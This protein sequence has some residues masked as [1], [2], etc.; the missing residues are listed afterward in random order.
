MKESP[1][2]GRSRSPEPGEQWT[3]L[4]LELILV[5]ALALRLPGLADW[6]FNPDE[7]MIFSVASWQHLADCITDLPTEPHP[8]LY[9]L[10]VR[11]TLAMGDSL[12]WLRLPSLI[13]SLFAIHALFLLARSL[14]DVRTALLSAI[15]LVFAS[16]P[17]TSAQLLRSYSLWL[18]FQIYALAFFVQWIQTS[19]RRTL[20]LAS[21][22]WCLS[23]AT[24]YFALTFLPMAALLL[25]RGHRERPMTRRQLGAL[26]WATLPFLLL[27]ALLFQFHF[28]PALLENAGQQAA[29]QRALAEGLGGGLANL[30]LAFVSL[31]R[32]LV[33]PFAI[34]A[35]LYLLITGLLQSF[36]AHKR[37]AV[38]LCSF[39]LLQAILLSATGLYPLSGSRHN[40]VLAVLLLPPMAWA[41]LS[42]FRVSSW[43]GALPRLLVLLAFLLTG[44][45]W[46][47][48]PALH[49]RPHLPGYV[50]E[51]RIPR[52]VIENSDL[53]PRIRDGGILIL[54]WQ[55]FYALL[56]LF[57]EARPERVHVRGPAW[58]ITP[59]GK[60]KVLVAGSFELRGEPQRM[61]EQDHLLGLLERVQLDDPQLRIWKQE[62]LY[63]AHAGWRGSLFE[64][65]RASWELPEDPG[66]LL[67]QEVE[68]L[69]AWQSFDPVRYRSF[70]LALEKL[71]QQNR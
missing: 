29:Q 7:G 44:T 60:G 31:F 70:M 27:C 48:V 24:H 4:L 67:E 34:F 22:F 53:F 14:Y 18:C 20:A 19:T 65:M 25:W 46:N 41:V 16:Y 45:L 61:H 63:L 6:W 47:W 56:P 69:F 15:L 51:Q 10:L 33:P 64:I 5:L 66:F 35:A 57:Y 23:L 21:L 9:Y 1:E 40:V 50:M 49:G 17:A 38:L 36:S 43:P 32:L 37:L 39:P 62:R 12:F 3:R 55:T 8:P 54:D 58:H 71:L 42:L 28:R 59:F 13:A 26:A 68:G 30:G 11:C 52:K 2:S